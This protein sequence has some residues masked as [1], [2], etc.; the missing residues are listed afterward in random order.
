MRECIVYRLGLAVNAML[1]ENELVWAV[2]MAS[3]RTAA[4]PLRGKGQHAAGT[5]CRIPRALSGRGRHRVLPV[6]AGKPSTARRSPEAREYMRNGRGACRAVAKEY[7]AGQFG[8]G[9][10]GAMYR[11]R[12][13]E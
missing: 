11:N 1:T 8:I 10:L 2:S 12:G 5:Q 6:N 3:R 9:Q 7:P 4:R 13:L